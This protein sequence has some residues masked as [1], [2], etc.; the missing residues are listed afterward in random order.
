MRFVKEEPSLKTGKWVK[1]CKGCNREFTLK[2]FDEHIIDIARSL[3][4]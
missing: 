2:E 1:T 3:R 4:V